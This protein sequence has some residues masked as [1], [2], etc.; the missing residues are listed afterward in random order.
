MEFGFIGVGNMGGALATAICRQVGGEHVLISRK[1]TALLPAQAEVLGCHHGTVAQVAESCK[2]IFLGVKPQMLGDVFEEISLILQNRTTP[3]VLVSM[4][5][6]VTMERLEAMVGIPCPILRLM[7]NTPVG[8]GQGMTLYCGN[9]AL[10]QKDLE[11]CLSALSQSGKLDPLPEHL[12]DIGT[13]VAGCSPAFVDLFV[14]A[15]ADGGVACGLPRAKAMEYAARSLAGS[16]ALILESGRHPG[17][18]KDAVCSPGGSTIQGVRALEN[19]GF[20]SSIIE[21]V[22]AAYQKTQGL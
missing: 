10:S 22:V 19:G 11:I 2:Y 21:A 9:K 8:I 7:P 1:N 18:L 15:L 16:A 14:E 3:F 17:D 12:F 13:V 5:A 20:R 6:G 4:A